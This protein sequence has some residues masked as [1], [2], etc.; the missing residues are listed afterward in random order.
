MVYDTLTK[1]EY[2]FD[3]TLV[4]WK[5]KPV[6]TELKPGA[7][8]HHDKPYPVPRAHEDVFCKEIE[9]FCQLDVLKEVN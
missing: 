7:K 2:L 4:T 5:N 1:H 6:D 3:G 8:P 9:C